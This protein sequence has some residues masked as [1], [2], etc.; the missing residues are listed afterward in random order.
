MKLKITGDCLQGQNIMRIGIEFKD[1]EDTGKTIADGNDRNIRKSVVDD[2]CQVLSRHGGS[3]TT[4]QSDHDF[5]C[6]L[7]WND[8]EEICLSTQYC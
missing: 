5:V 1:R 7:Q 8:G 3:C 4:Q 6:L 2:I